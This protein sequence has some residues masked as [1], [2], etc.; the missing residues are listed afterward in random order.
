M[1]EAFL[2]Y[3]WNYKLLNTSDLY[4]TEGES[5]EIIDFGLLN[6]HSGP[7]FFNGKIKVGNT[8]WVGN[9]EIHVKSSDWYRHNHQEDRAYDNVIL[10]V[11]YEDDKP[12]INSNGEII[13]TLVLRALFDDNLYQDYNVFIKPQIPCI[14]QMSNIDSIYISAFK[15]QQLIERL[16]RKSKEIEADLL[17]TDYDWEQI[18]YEH[19]CKSIG[20]KV[21]QL[22]FKLLAEYTPVKLLYKTTDIK[23]VESILYGNAGFLE[24]QLDNEYYMSLQKEYRYQKQKHNFKSL[25]K[26]IWKFAKLRPSSFPSVRVAQVAR[27]VMQNQHLFDSLIR[28]QPQ[29]EDIRKILSVCVSDGFWFTHYTFTTESKAIKKSLGKQ[30]IDSIIINT[31]V[32]FSFLYFTHKGKDNTL[33]WG[34][35]LL[36]NL[37]AEDNNITRLFEKDIKIDTAYDS[38]AI[39]EAYNNYCL[40][41]K[42]LSC[43][44]GVKLLK[45]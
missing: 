26:H 17:R 24:E 20:A 45:Q 8:T 21:N 41:K 19:L 34:K 32:P 39:I 40:Y 28:K 18:F 9:I 36:E 33:S 14:D 5:L 12:L 23:V 27:L 31:M 3:L 1:Q 6:Q 15:D 13:P 30:I 38:Q 10:H 29:I 44:I 16:Q 22:P 42:C 37:K 7:D 43:T 11:V 2:Q 25:N 35:Y 4:T